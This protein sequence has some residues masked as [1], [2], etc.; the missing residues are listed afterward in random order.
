MKRRIDIQLPNDN[1]TIYLSYAEIFHTYVVNAG[2]WKSI[3]NGV[4]VKSFLRFKIVMRITHSYY[5]Y[6]YK[7]CE[8]IILYGNTANMKLKEIACVYSSLVCRCLY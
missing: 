1:N 4:R 6:K 8:I 7:S 5:V 3:P 2:E